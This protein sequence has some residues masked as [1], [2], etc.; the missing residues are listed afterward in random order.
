MEVDEKKKALPYSF[1]DG[2]KD[3]KTY[4]MTLWLGL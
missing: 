2:K 1:A 3:F 4:F